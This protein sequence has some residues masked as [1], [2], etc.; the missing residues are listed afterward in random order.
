V[1]RENFQEIPSNNSSNGRKSSK[2]VSMQNKQNTNQNKD[3]I[4]KL[5]QLIKKPTGMN[6]N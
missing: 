1:L 2:N 3:H 6:G 5:R 4:L